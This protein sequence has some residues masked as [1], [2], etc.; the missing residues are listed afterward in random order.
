M[1]LLTPSE[2]KQYSPTALAFLGDSVYERL[3]REKYV[4]DANMPA[5]KLHDLTIEKVCAEFQAEAAEELITQGLLTDEELDIFR[6]GRNSS[7]ISAPKH[8]TVAQ[9]RT[10]TGLECLFGYLHLCGRTERIEE[11]FC[12]ICEKF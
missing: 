10:A 4:L 3:V 5:R 2:A 12:H 11:L 1:K 8:S 9:Y 6:R 7:G